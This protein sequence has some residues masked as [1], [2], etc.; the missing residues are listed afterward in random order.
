MNNLASVAT[1]QDGILKGVLIG[2]EADALSI[3]RAHT[4]KQSALEQ[5]VALCVP[6]GMPGTHPGGDPALG[7]SCL[8]GDGP[9]T[10]HASK[11]TTMSNAKEAGRALALHL[12]PV[13]VESD[14]RLCVSKREE[15]R[16]RPHSIELGT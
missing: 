5:E 10:H 6:V 8:C 15:P 2:V 3:K 7:G 1:H 4:W 16:L 9:A 14:A 13:V 11:N 12:R